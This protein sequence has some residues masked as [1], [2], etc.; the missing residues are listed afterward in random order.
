MK[1]IAHLVIALL[2]AAAAAQAP[3][4]D[5]DTWY[6]TVVG[7]AVYGTRSGR[8][9]TVIEVVRGAD[10]QPVAAIIGLDPAID[11]DGRALPLAWDNVRGQAGRA[12][13]IAP[14]TAAAVR[15]LVRREG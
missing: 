4:A 8:I 2:P 13:L 3:T 10:G 5:G 14:W 12:T 7:M 6:D 11:P 9:G 15:W 1:W